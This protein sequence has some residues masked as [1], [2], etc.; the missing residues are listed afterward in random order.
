MF[1]K[2][3]V[4]LIVKNEGP[5]LMEWVAYYRCLGFDQVVVYDNRS[6]DGSDLILAQMAKANLIMHKFWNKGA[7]E[8][9]QISAYRDCLQ[10]IQS[11]WLLFVDADEFLV[12]HK[13]GN[14]NEFLAGYDARPEVTTIGFNWRIF[15]DS[16]MSGPD[17]RLITER[18]NRAADYDFPINF[19]LKSFTRVRALGRIVNMH[20]TETTGLKVHPS[21]AVLNMSNW[22]ISDETEFSVAQVNHY[23]TKTYEEYMVKKARGNADLTDDH[24]QK[25]NTYHDRAFHGSNRNEAIDETAHRYLLAV[26]A[27]IASMESAMAKAEQMVDVPV[28]KRLIQKLSG[29][30][31]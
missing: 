31:S 4:C 29:N 12:L 28:W 13:H 8:S 20:I 2:S 16:G 5:Y 25:Y 7:D 10:W 23:Y 3:A 9:P 17:G 15:G 21:G 30:R 14:V 19:H 11:E 1:V 27:E 26:R 6:T 18:F 24:D 22:G